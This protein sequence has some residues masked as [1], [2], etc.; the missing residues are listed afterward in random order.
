MDR[1]AFIGRLVLATLARPRAAPA[2]P[3]RKVARIGIRGL[4]VTSDLVGPQPRSPSTSALLQGLRELGY[5]YG[6][7]NVKAAKSIDL[8]IPQSVLLRAD[9][10]LQ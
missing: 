4:G 1:R 9:E 10:V 8:A 3:A 7:I 5:V 6:V 2:Q